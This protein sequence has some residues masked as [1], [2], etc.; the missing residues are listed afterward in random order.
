VTGIPADLLPIRR[1]A[2]L[3]YRIA[4]LVAEPMLR[5]LFNIEVPGSDHIPRH[6]PYV[7]I[8]N[9]LNWLD[10]FAILLCFPLEPRIHFLADPAI[11]MTRR[12]QWLV[13]RRTGGYVAVDRSQHRDVALFDRVYRCLELGAVVTIYPEGNYGPA[14]GR[15]LPFKKGFA[16]FALRAGVPVLPVALS[17]TKEPWLRKRIRVVVVEPISTAGHNVESLV[18][19]AT[20]RL[21]A[22][23]PAYE[24]APGPKP[25]RRQL[26]HLF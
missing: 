2:N 6:G 19:L 3:V 12:L 18:E 17:G 14:E 1:E 16:H 15:L 25:L 22:L 24:E 23:L 5:L 11:L 13:V 9:H 4:R 21:A 20:A 8:A 10:S 7:L 26:T